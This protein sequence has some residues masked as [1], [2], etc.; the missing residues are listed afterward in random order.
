[1]RLPQIF[2]Y[3]V[4][5]RYPDFIGCVFVFLLVFILLLL[6]S[7]FLKYYNLVIFHLSLF[8]TG[9]VGWTF[10]EY[11]TH[12]YLMYAAK[13]ENWI[14]DFNHTYHHTH[15]TNI[16]ISGT[17]RRFLL[18]GC[19]ILLILCIWMNNYFTL[20]AGFLCGFPGYTLMHFFLHQKNAQIFFGKLVKYHIYHHCKYP[21]KCFGISVT[22][23]DDIFG[24]IPVNPGVINDR[25]MDFYFMHESEKLNNLPPKNTKTIR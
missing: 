19:I 23:W 3:K 2:R 16:K 4:N 14:I 24:T 13:K 25:I 22:W 5:K 11:M 21:D 6:M 20:A 10:S 7:V 18:V 1:M 15:P 12:R 8:F 9:W 17:Q